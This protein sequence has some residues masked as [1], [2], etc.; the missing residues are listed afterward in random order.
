MR[1]NSR[2]G[3]SHPV[4]ARGRGGAPHATQREN[5]DAGLAEE[6]AGLLETVIRAAGMDLES[7]RIG[8]AGRRR[9]LRVV[10]DADG[11]VSLDSI[12]EISRELSA[13]LDSAGAMGDAP[14]TLEVSSPGVDRPLTEPRHWRRA[15]GRLV[16]VA[17]AE[18][19]DSRG[20]PMPRGRPAVIE[21]RLSA[22]DDHGVT[23]EINGGHREFGYAELGPGRVRVEF[24]RP[25]AE[26]AAGGPVAG[27]PMAGDAAPQAA[28]AGPGTGG[29]SDG[30]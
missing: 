23:V 12:A 5:R 13:R 28:L 2:R 1:G 17:L 10:V 19:A 14:Y 3:S 27:D 18:P 29:R 21:G 25:E 7:V 20:W 8:A 9:V 16:K 24:G 30:H 6:L 11:G 22:A 15:V 4:R 26:S